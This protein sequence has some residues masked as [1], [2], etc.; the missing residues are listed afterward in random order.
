MDHL[1]YNNNSNISLAHIHFSSIFFSVDTTSSTEYISSS[2]IWSSFCYIKSYIPSRK[3]CYLLI[4][5]HFLL[6][7]WKDN[8]KHPKV[9]CYVKLLPIYFLIPGWYFI[10][11]RT[12]D[13]GNSPGT[14]YTTMDSARE[15]KFTPAGFG[16]RVPKKVWSWTHWYTHWH[17][18]T[19]SDTAGMA[20]IQPLI[21]DRGQRD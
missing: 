1:L 7:Q 20:W 19:C 16:N 17:T 3:L 12:N 11:K 18:S 5:Y 15:G 6:V 2:Q 10:S 4:L 13:P 8:K 21:A 14:S 9:N